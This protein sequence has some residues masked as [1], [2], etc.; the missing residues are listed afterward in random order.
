MT[1]G[2]PADLRAWVEATLEGR[3]TAAT[4]IGSGAS[5]Q[6]WRLTLHGRSV[7][8]RV[9]S[10]T[11]PV[12]GTPLNLAREA[13]VYRALEG[14]GLPLP[15]LYGVAP[16]GMALLMQDAEGDA[17]LAAISDPGE[18]AAVGREYLGWLGRLHLLDAD[19]LDLPG[20]RRPGSDHRR[21]D[22]GL[23]ASIFAERAGAWATI[24]VPFALEWLEAVAPGAS[25]TALCHG[26]AGPGNFLFQ[27]GAVTALLDWEF[28]H[29]GDPQDDLAWVAVRNH[30]LGRPMDLGDVLAAWQATTHLAIDA[31]HLEYYRVLVLVRMAI[32]CD[33]SLAWKDGIEDDT[34]RTQALLR[35]WLGVAI[36]KA[37]A[38]AGCDEPDLGPL[39]AEAERLLAASPH[40]TLLSLIPPLEPME[41]L[42]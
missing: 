25:A 24:S 31:S 28:A 14:A 9:D 15:V 18:R 29:I 19:A 7:V 41:L 6:I 17:A 21:D 13:V 8:L 38:L 39:T 22:L 35:P 37:L 3:V 11:G 4:R 42:S 36:P 32:S 40:A 2:P 27:D 33:A 12:A 30:L 23:W 16:D 20:I 34:I 5:R 1:E 10:G 26:D